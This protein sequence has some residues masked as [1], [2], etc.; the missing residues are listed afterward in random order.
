MG[1]RTNLWLVCLV[2][3]YSCKRE[4]DL[5]IEEDDTTFPVVDI[6]APIESSIYQNGDTVFITGSVTDNEL[7]SGTLLLKNDTTAV[8]YMNEYHNV[9]ELSSASISYFY[10]VSGIIQNE[11][12]TFTATYEDHFPNTTAITRHLVFQP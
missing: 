9:H 5:P 10:V 6:L 4:P 2:L 12:V 11:A 7:H 3:I 1:N 8:E